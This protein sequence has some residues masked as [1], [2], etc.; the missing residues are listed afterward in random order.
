[1]RVGRCHCMCV[2]V[3]DCP[4]SYCNLDACFDNSIPGSS[5]R[6][7][8]LQNML[9]LRRSAVQAK[10]D[11]FKRRRNSD[12]CCKF[13]SVPVSFTYEPVQLPDEHLPR[14][15][16]ITGIGAIG[17]RS[18]RRVK[19]SPKCARVCNYIKS[20]APPQLPRCLGVIPQGRK[21][22][23]HAVLEASVHVQH[24]RRESW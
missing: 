24:H 12:G 1:M 5:T 4:V 16:A 7:H 20:C 13:T 11:D 8:I 14:C 21:Q 3:F 2:C 22:L 17:R 18:R 6:E 19:I 23:L 10:T 9:L 15:N